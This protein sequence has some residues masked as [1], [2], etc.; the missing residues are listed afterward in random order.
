MF[1]T[2]ATGGFNPKNLSVGAYNNPVFEI[3]I[4]F[5]MFVAGANFT[6]HY[7]VLHGNIK[8]LFKDKEFL[9]YGG[10]V[11]IAI[12]AITTDLR[13]Y[14]YNSIFTALRYA[15]F[16]VVSILTTTGFVT[17]DYDT[18]PAFSKCILL[19]LMFIGGCAGST[20]GAIK[21]I[22]ILLLF[23]KANRDFHKLIHPRAVTPIRVG[24]KIVSEDTMNYITSFFFLYILIFVI[25]TFIM[26]ILG[27]DIL[28]AMSSVAATLG[29]VGPGLGMVGPSQNYA[30]IPPLGKITLTICMLLGRLELYTVLVLLV[31]GF[32][33]K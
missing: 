29:N 4:T 1:G 8:S 12:L 22:R 11:L 7:Q 32:W 5:F 20:G 14:I 24:N 2:M 23:K 19:I 6:L 27:L 13:V 30:F 10:V 25:S 26:S 28:S 17:T 31:P 3:I 33:R 16:Q 18:W 9:F 21:N 15:S